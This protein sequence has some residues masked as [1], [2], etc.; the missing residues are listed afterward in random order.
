MPA[1]AGLNVQRGR[2]EQ[3]ASVV[4][5]HADGSYDWKC[6]TCGALHERHGPHRGPRKRFC[7]SC[8]NRAFHVKNGRQT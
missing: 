2:S 4:H 1:E 8:Q 3:P 7:K 5:Y 6:E